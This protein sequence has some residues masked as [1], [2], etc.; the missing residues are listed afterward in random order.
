VVQQAGQGEHL[1]R[2]ERIDLVDLVERTADL[3][4]AGTEVAPPA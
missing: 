4:T 1:G 2:P 3:R